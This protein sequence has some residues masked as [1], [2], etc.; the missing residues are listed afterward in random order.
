M[1]TIQRNGLKIEL[2]NGGYG[3]DE[4]YIKVDGKDYA[5]IS[6]VHYENSI[7]LP[8]I[9]NWVVETYNFDDVNSGQFIVGRYPE[10]NFSIGGK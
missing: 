5:T 2:R 10:K 4:F 7:V 3:E 6:G 8:E 9:I 1:K